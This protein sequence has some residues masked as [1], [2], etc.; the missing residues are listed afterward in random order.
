MSEKL[1]IPS[2]IPPEWFEPCHRCMQCGFIE[3]YEK[4]FKGNG[5]SGC[6]SCGMMGW[7]MSSEGYDAIRFLASFLRDFI[8]PDE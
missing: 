7:R 6:S 4:A 1:Q 2:G 5:V 8:N 3:R